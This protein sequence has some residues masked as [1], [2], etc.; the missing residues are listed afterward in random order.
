MARKTPPAGSQA[1]RAQAEEIFREKSKRDS[2]F[3]TYDR[4]A[5]LH[6]LMVHQIELEMQNEELRR[7]QIESHELQTRY[8]DLYDSA[9]V[10]YLTFDVTGIISSANGIATRLLGV[11]RSLLLKTSLLLFVKPEFRRTFHL[12]TVAVLESPHTV[13]TCELVLKRN[14]KDDEGF[15]AM[16]QSTAVQVNGHI[17]IRTVLTD[18][19]DLKQAQNEAKAAHEELEKKV[20]ERTTE[21][22]EANVSLQ[23][24]V[25]VR[26]RTEERIRRDKMVQEGISRML[27]TAI[28]CE[29]EE[30]LGLV[31]LQLAEELT[32]SKI[33][34]IGEI[35]PDSHL[36]NIAMSNPGWERC[37]M[38]DKPGHRRLPG[39]LAIHGLYSRV[40]KD[41]K[42]FMTNEP[43]KHLDSIGI[44]VG[45]PPL[46]A[47]L[48]VPLLERGNTVGLV[49]VGNREG[50]YTMD[51]L[52]TLEA[53]APA[54]VQSLFRKRAEDE[55]RK[56]EQRYRDLFNAIDEGFCI[57]EVIFGE[58][59]RPVDYRFLEI[60][61]SFERQTG[62]SD[63][64]GKRMRDLIPQ[65]EEHWF[66]T[67]GRIALTGEPLRFQHRADQLGFWYDV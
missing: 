17:D 45:H 60:N 9:P 20:K 42:S 12:H 65:H 28:T 24:E 51:D 59:Q 8:M 61:A 18:I 38:C 50:G 67:Y 27:T 41:G 14:L 64:A 2:S 46:T 22:V 29:T 19:S 58:N 5:L 44:P 49:A 32:K 54:I 62:L 63:A 36:Y 26:Q 23:K 11:D 34:F 15:W 39:A 37:N 53:L 6:E 13:H 48:G 43:D 52:Q 33:S 47:F 16:F 57:I 31:C 10:G 56:S 3:H 25:E 40:L 7:S 30:Q 35:H 1:L 21:L 66:E 4:D 55:L